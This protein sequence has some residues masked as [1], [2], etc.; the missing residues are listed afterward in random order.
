MIRNNPPINHN[1]R[2]YN[3]ERRTTLFGKDIIKFVKQ[4]KITPVN[5]RIIE[6]LVGSSGSIGANYCEATEAESKKDFIHKLGIAKKEVKETK[7][8]IELLA[9]AEPTYKTQLR[10]FW[11][12]ADELLK[13]FSQSHITAKKSL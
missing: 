5:K 4:L 6:Q 8:W 10:I 3:L 12:E 11:K 9:V 1:N 13:I 2:I 7:H